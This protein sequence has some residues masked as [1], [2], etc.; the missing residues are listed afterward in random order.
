MKLEYTIQYMFD[1]YPTVIPDRR[2]ALNHLFYVVGNGYD[3]HSG[4]L[5]AS[6]YDYS[7]RRP[8]KIKRTKKGLVLGPDGCA[9]QRHLDIVASEELFREKYSQKV[10][11]KP[12]LFTIYGDHGEYS[13]INTYP[14]DIK[15]D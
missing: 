7:G 4:E 12:Y 2:S 8:R 1:Y 13:C 3:W 5:V 15:P 11:G 9:I 10:Y 6:D 14:D